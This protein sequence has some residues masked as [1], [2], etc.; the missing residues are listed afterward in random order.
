[1]RGKNLSYEYL[2]SFF[3][4]NNEGMLCRKI[5]V[6]KAKAGVVEGNSDNLGYKYVYQDNSRLKVHRIAYCV[7]SG[8][9]LN[10]DVEIDHIDGNPSKNNISNLRPCNRSE[11]QQNRGANKNNKLGYKGV[12]IHKK[13]G[14]Y[15]GRWMYNGILHAT[16]YHE[17]PNQAYAELLLIKSNFK[18]EFINREELK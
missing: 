4:I 5:S 10:G 2:S 15:F 14:K 3:Y 7:F 16:K 6:K 8:K 1:M 11:N 13:T 9:D 12:C 18:S 17:E